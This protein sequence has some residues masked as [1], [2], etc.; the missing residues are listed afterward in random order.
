MEWNI[1]YEFIG[2]GIWCWIWCLF[3]LIARRITKLNQ[4]KLKAPPWMSLLSSKTVPLVC[5]LRYYF[6]CFTW[7]F[8]AILVKLGLMCYA[9]VQLI[10]MHMLFF[11]WS[12]IPVISFR[13]SM[14][15]LANY[16][17]IRSLPFRVWLTCYILITVFSSH[18][19]CMNFSAGSKKIFISG[20]Q[21]APMAR[22]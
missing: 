2:T 14:L 8:C 22:L 19:L 21:N 16:I 9:V 18:F 12:Q 10:S 4:R 20:W 3:C 6:L 17:S 5:F 11:Y 7:F 15:S 13:C 1:F